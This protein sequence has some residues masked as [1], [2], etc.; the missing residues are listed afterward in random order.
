MWSFSYYCCISES[1][2]EWYTCCVAAMCIYKGAAYPQGAKW[3][4]GCQYKCECTDAAR[5]TYRCVER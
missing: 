5:G 3:E 1:V 4:D 2:N